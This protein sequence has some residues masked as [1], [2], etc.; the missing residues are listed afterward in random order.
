MNRLVQLDWKL[1]FI[2]QYLNN[3]DVNCLIAI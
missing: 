3:D 2:E 1:T